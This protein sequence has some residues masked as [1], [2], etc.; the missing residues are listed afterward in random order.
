MAII[1]QSGKCRKD[2]RGDLEHEERTAF[3]RG[4]TATEGRLKLYK[5]LKAGD[6]VVV[7]TGNLE[8]YPV[9]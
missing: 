3:H 8:L 2:E 7:E 1:T 9:V 4:G 6:K 5:L